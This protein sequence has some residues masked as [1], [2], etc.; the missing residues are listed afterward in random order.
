VLKRLIIA[1]VAG[2]AVIAALLAVLAW[3]VAP[4]DEPVSR[5]ADESLTDVFETWFERRSPARTD[6]EPTRYGAIVPATEGAALLR[7]CADEAP[8]GIA[9][10]WR[11]TRA[12]IDE[13][14]Q[15]LPMFLLD[16]RLDPL[17][18]Y[19]RQYGG[20]HSNGRRLIYVSLL[21]GL[22][23]DDVQGGVVTLCDRRSIVWGVLFDVETRA[24][25]QV[26]VRD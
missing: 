18:S 16:A 4:T 1:L 12:M 3:L 22:S 5:Q 19:A 23:P 17:D 25:S 13:V 7:Q 6:F 8:A 21:P 15:R 9:G 24:V 11:P 26:N 20:V 14:E 2:S 10:Y